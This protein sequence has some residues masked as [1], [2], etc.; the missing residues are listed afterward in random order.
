VQN[1]VTSKKSANCTPQD[2]TQLLSWAGKITLSRFSPEVLDPSECNARRCSYMPDFVDY[3]D[4]D[5][6]VMPRHLSEYSSNV[7]VYIAGFVAERLAKRIQCNTCI[8]AVTSNGDNS[9]KHSYFLKRK[10][11][12]G[13][14]LPSQSLVQI[15]RETEKGLRGLTSEGKPPKGKEILQLQCNV[16]M[17]MQDHNIFPELAEHLVDNVYPEN[18]LV[19]LIKCIVKMYIKVRCHHLANMHNCS[20]H[21]NIIRQQLTKSILFQN[22]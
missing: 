7:V 6:V 22:Q 9:L 3:P 1:D 15:C 16:V 18:H 19:M 11:N 5:Y 8:T 13:L 12:G 21:A 4:H 17:S 20:L 14:Y 10:N 2:D